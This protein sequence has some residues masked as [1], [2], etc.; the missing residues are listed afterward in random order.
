MIK[1]HIR[2]MFI[3]TPTS[4]WTL[5]LRIDFNKHHTK[6]IINFD[7]IYNHFLKYINIIKKNWYNERTIINI[8]NKQDANLRKI[9]FKKKKKK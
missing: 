1:F 5:M 7:I 2:L 9:M 8:P 6:L 4:S 3:K